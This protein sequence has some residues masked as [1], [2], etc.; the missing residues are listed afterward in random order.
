MVDRPG[1]LDAVVGY[2]PGGVHGAGVVDENVHSGIAV[3]HLSRQVA[4]GGL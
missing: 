1:Q 3:E 2:L 4:H